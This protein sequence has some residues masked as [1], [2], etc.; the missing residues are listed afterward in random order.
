MA[1][2]IARLSFQDGLVFALTNMNY[3]FRPYCCYQFSRNRLLYRLSTIFIYF[4]KP[5]EGRYKNRYLIRA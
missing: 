5:L 1:E 2:D 4:S 3:S